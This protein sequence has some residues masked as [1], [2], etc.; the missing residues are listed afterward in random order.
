[1]P[2]AISHYSVQLK[3][4]AVDVRKKKVTLSCSSVSVVLLRKLSKSSGCRKVW[5]KGE[6]KD[7]DDESFSKR[8][9]GSE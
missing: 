7:D 2:A 1:M 4:D 3:A 6:E 8:R 9:R 5:K